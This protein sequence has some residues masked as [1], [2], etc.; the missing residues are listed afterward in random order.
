MPAPPSHRAATAGGAVGD[1]TDR[2][3][4]G[5]GD[6]GYAGNAM[7]LSSSRRYMSSRRNSLSALPPHDSRQYSHYENGDIIR[8]A[9]GSHLKALE[10]QETSR[11]VSDSRC[12]LT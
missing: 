7:G 9:S 3:E 1:P 12:S 2:F 6:G 10:D 8:S 5:G 4:S 11:T